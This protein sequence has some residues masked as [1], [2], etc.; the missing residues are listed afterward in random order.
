MIKR[1]KRNYIIVIMMSCFMI[2]T[3]A[4]AL[5]GFEQA[6]SYGETDGVIKSV[7]VREVEGGTYDDRYYYTE[8]AVKYDYTIGGREYSGTTYLREDYTGREGERVTVIY[9]KS[10]PRKSDIGSRTKS[11]GFGI[12]SLISTAVLLIYA[13]YDM[14]NWVRIRKAENTQISWQSL[15]SDERLALNNEKKK[16]TK[17]NIILLIASALCTFLLLFFAIPLWVFTVAKMID[18]KLCYPNL[19]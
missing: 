17:L 7:N 9:D 10:S 16:K 2:F 8:S 11:L 12:T 6:L 18:V 3:L 19:E 4:F 13:I 15:S 14:I 1:A 5:V